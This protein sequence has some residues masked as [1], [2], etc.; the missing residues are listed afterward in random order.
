MDT[1]ADGVPMLTTPVLSTKI[2]GMLASID[3]Q[4][5]IL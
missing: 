1:D 3:K 2:R 4:G 5:R